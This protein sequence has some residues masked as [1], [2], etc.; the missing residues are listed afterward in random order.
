MNT[1]LS[2]LNRL[3]EEIFSHPADEA[4]LRR[5]GAGDLIFRLRR[6]RLPLYFR[7]IRLY[8]ST[9]SRLSRRL[10]QQCAAQGDWRGIDPLASRLSIATSSAILYA[11]AVLN[12]CGIT[13][14]RSV[15]ERVLQFT[16][17][18]LRAQ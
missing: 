8:A 11:A 15:A 3:C 10:E 16:L 18:P 14:R 1:E 17:R 6:E 13:I 2:H 12:C 9:A 5:S 7:T 4:F